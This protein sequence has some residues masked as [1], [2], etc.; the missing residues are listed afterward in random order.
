MHTHKPTYDTNLLRT[1]RVVQQTAFWCASCRL[2]SNDL[3]VLPSPA[4]GGLD[5]DVTM[6]RVEDA[7]RASKQASQQ[8]KRASF[9]Q[10][11]RVQESSSVRFHLFQ[12]T[13]PRP[14][15]DTTAVF[16]VCRVL[17]SSLS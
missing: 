8:E 14:N 3:P 10:P 15:H 17:A 4:L 9:A 7:M 2:A 5:P 6:A 16:V 11:R 13:P 12:P 1:L